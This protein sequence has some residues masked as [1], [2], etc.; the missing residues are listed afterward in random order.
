MRLAALSIAT[1]LG[2]GYF[3]F[4]PGT[5]GSLG[6]LLLWA[7][8]PQNP[9]VTGAAILAICALG[10]WAAGAA[11]RHFGGID[12]GPVVIDEVMGMLVTLFMIPAGW[13]GALAGFLLFRAFDVIK[14]WPANRLEHLPGGIGV[15]ADDFMAAVYS[16]LALRAI[17]A[18]GVL[19]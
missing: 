15:M 16:N 19:G 1:A 10:A 6:G 2:I 18:V 11:E 17:L 4:A 14:P 13:P 3:P 9:A 12:P 7:V 8:L 5:I